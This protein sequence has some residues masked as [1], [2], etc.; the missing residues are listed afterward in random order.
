MFSC[1]LTE[2]ENKK[3]T[4]IMFWKAYNV[5]ESVEE[6]ITPCIQ[7]ESNVLLH[8]YNLHKLSWQ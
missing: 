6:V 7:I 3:E 8:I 2:A 4:K 1:L 5:F